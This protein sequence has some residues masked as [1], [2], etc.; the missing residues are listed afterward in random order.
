MTKI[1]TVRRLLRRAVRGHRAAEGRFSLR[2]SARWLRPA[3]PARRTRRSTRPQ[4]RP[5]V[6][7]AVWGTRLSGGRAWRG[8]AALRR[9]AGWRDPRAESGRRRAAVPRHRRLVTAGGEQGLLGLA[10]HPQYP[11]P[12]ILRPVHGPRRRHA[13][14][15]TG[16]TGTRAPGSR[17]SSSSATTRT[18]TTTAASW[19][20]APNGRLYFT[21][22]DGGAGGDPGEPLAEHALP[23]REA[24]LD[25]RRDKG[26]RIE[27]LGLR[28]AWRFTFDRGTGDLYIGDVGQNE[29]EEINYLRA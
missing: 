24:A 27:A 22:G 14:S 2:S 29:L 3:A 12:R 6:V 1:F 4:F 7:R 13:S 10:F 28:N 25:E 8:R 11:N 16:P 23:L 26:I 21:I 5:R 18:G 15:S 17:A 9:R 19:P 20:S